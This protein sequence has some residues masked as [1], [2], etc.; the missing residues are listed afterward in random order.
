[1]AGLRAGAETALYTAFPPLIFASI[2]AQLAPLG[3]TAGR[4]FIRNQQMKLRMGANMGRI[5][6]GYFTDSRAAFTM[7]QQGTRAI[8]ESFSRVAYG[9][10]ARMMYRR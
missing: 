6:S 3:Y 8:Q 7:R 2:G 5:G 10:E 4:D 1:M 9:N